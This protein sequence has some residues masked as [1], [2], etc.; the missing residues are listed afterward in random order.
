MPNLE[1]AIK[2][3]INLI[4][5]EKT[6]NLFSKYSKTYLFT[7]ECIKEYL[8]RERFN[9]TKALTVLSSGDHVFNL[10]C[11]DV[12]DIDTFDINELTY[13]LFY[14]KRAIILKLPLPAFK[15]I[16]YNL[17]KDLEKDLKLLEILKDELPK[18][19]YEYYRYIFT[20]CQKY[21]PDGLKK[22][23]WGLAIYI[24]NDSIY[25]ENIKEYIKLRQK[26]KKAHITF[27]F[28]DVLELPNKL[29]NLYDIILL[30]NISD[31]LYLKIPNFNLY[32]NIFSIF[33]RR[34]SFN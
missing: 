8:N 4:N 25:L 32:K 17:G 24:G 7:T 13:Y 31:Y 9:K 12:Y 2:G 30:S 3:S 27:T 33:K 14:L 21:Q 18:D 15:Y 16:T 5:E 34:W 29:T 26:L 23:I 6:T 1:D 19:V 22:L 10:I 28:S 11:K 20:Y